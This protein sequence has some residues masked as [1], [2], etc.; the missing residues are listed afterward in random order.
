MVGFSEIEPGEH[1]NADA[2]QAEEG[3][4]GLPAG[5]VVEQAAN[6]R[7]HHRHHGHAHGHVADH[8]GRL[9]HWHHVTH[10]GARQHEAGND[11][12]LR[13]AP[14]HE[15]GDVGCEHADERCD[16]HDGD[17]DE[18]HRPAS[19]EIGERA[20]DELQAGGGGKIARNGKLHH[21]I[22]GLEIK[23]HGRKRGQEHVH[24]KRCDAGDDD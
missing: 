7:P 18:H 17:A 13:H 2:E 19:E 24:A 8:R 9:F 23:R 1:Q 6:R 22:I 15:N 21:G 4:A 10:D 14:D 12:R 11:G 3:E 5:D 20:D 16:D